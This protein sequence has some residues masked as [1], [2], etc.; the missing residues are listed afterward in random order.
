VK[1]KAREAA[2]ARRCSWSTAC[3]AGTAG[4]SS[5]REAAS[6]SD[7]RGQIIIRD[8]TAA[9]RSRRR[10]RPTGSSF[11]LWP[12][13][14]RSPRSGSAGR[15]PADLHDYIGQ[16]SSWPGEA[17]PDTGGAGETSLVK[18][19]AEAMTLVEQAIKYTRSLT[20]ELSPPILYDVGFEA[21]VEWLAERMQET[22]GVPFQVSNDGKPKAMNENMGVLLFRALRSCL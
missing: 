7:G 5:P 11:G 3:A 4:S 6:A 19:V 9:R 18:S 10:S 2:W 22:Y 17:E 14:F 13:S 1:S 12:R 20:F 21:A 8:V 16:A 15:S